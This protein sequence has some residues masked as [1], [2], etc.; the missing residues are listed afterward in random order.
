M[1]ILYF[2]ALMFSL[3][4]FAEVYKVVDN[5]GNITY[6]DQPQPDAKLV[7]LALPPVNKMP[8]KMPRVQPEP[9]GKP[10]PAANPDA[11]GTQEAQQTPAF[12]GYTQAYILSPAHDQIIPNQQR[13]VIIQLG[14]QPQ[15]Q[16]GHRVQ[17]LSNGQPLGAPIGATAYQLEDLERGSYQIGAQI[18]S[19]EGKILLSLKPISIHVQRHFR[20]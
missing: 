8:R 13:N 9:I 2:I 20:R 16:P 17:F 7:P 3:P 6:T 5:N 4:V 10:E 15:L 12:A 19:A 14:L 18:R 11:E 1:R